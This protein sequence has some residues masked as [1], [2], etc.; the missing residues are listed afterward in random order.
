[1]LHQQQDRFTAFI[2]ERFS[3]I[4]LYAPAYK[5]LTRPH[6]KRRPIV[7][8]ASVFPGY[9]FA[10]VDIVGGDASRLTTTP[11]RVHWIRFAGEI[12]HIPDAVIT[13]LRRLEATG[14]LVKEELRDDPLRPGR[15][16]R[17]HTPVAD[18]NGI[19][20]RLMNCHGVLVDTAIGRLTA[21]IHL[22][23][24]L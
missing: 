7:V 13:E 15:R 12:E 19:V 2:A 6:G 20:I 16:V 5:R 17:V 22:I 10:H 24:P 21:P 11:F 4:E 14:E 23:T 18:I 1:M 3:H 8:T 9:V